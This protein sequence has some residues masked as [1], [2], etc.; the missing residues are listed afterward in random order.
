[1][2]AYTF[3]ISDPLEV[4]SLV[5]IS[6]E[7]AKHML[8]VMR[9]AKGD[10]V[11]LMNGRGVRATGS[12]H[13]AEKEWAEV[14]IQERE[15]AVA[16][17]PLL[18]AFAIPRPPRMDL[19]LEKGTELGVTAFW[20]FPGERSEKKSVSAQQSSRLRSIALAASKQS[21]RLWL[22]EILP[23]PALSRWSDCPL[24]AFFGDLNPEAPLLLDAVPS[25]PSSI[26]FVTGPE[27]GFSPEEEKQL[28]K[29]GVQGVK[30]H[31]SILRTDTASIAACALLTHRKS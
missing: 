24:P 26:L 11:V 23:M 19:I 8:R 27:A 17:T 9:L 30:L 10:Q 25:N 16:P 13:H 31:A 3:F 29:L 14:R 6:G 5:K 18:L 4:F 1:M 7:E 21:G 28:R 2:P 15:S 12:I 20:P 22:P